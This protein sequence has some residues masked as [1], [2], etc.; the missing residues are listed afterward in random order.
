[1]WP[2]ANVWNSIMLCTVRFPMTSSEDLKPKNG[3]AS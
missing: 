2:L 1:M 3:A